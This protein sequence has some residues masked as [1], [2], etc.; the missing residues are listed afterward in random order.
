MDTNLETHR[1]RSRR[2][3]KKSSFF[4]RESKEFPFENKRAINWYCFENET[5]NWAKQQSNCNLVSVLMGGDRVD[6]ETLNSTIEQWVK[7]KWLHNYV[8]F[9]FVYM[10]KNCATLDSLPVSTLTGELKSHRIYRSSLNTL[11]W[12]LGFF[13]LFFTIYLLTNRSWMN[14]WITLKWRESIYSRTADNGLQWNCQR[15]NVL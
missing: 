11:N 4:H 8:Y 5:E 13:L 2:T 14:V 3:R 6:G 15:K 10:L 7:S 12:F 9:C 1:I